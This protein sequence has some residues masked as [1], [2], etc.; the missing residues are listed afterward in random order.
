M[1]LQLSFFVFDLKAA[2]AVDHERGIPVALPAVYQAAGALE[3]ADPRAA[4]AACH[5]AP[6]SLAVRV[7]HGTCIISQSLTQQHRP[8]QQ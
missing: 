6:F 1:A 8:D 2:P 5:T 7:T 3:H 4:G